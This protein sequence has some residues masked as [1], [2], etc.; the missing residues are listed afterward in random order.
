MSDLSD[1]LEVEVVK[2]IFRT[3]SYPAPTVLAIALFTT[4]PTDA[5][6]GTEVTGGSYARVSYN[7][8]DANW[9]A[10]SGTDGITSNINPITFPSPTANWGTVT[11][12]AIYDAA[13]SGNMLFS[14][15]LSSSRVVNN[16]D[17][18]PVFAA[19]ALVVTFA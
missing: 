4:D 14:S 11:H 7:P 13:T 2:H 12:F 9:A 18:A 6:T 5:A 3:G 19:D 8:L 10:T 17:T 1:Y 15:A 16:G